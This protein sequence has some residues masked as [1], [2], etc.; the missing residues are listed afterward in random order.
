MFK[1]RAAAEPIFVCG[2]GRSGTTWI[3][4]ALGQSP[5]L[6]YIEEAWLI[7]KLEELTEWFTMV[8]DQ[9]DAF[10][11]WR[12][13]GVDRRAF[14]EGVARMY[15]DLLMRAANGKRFVEKTPEWNA[16][17]LKF[18]HELFPDAYYVLI[19]RDGRN[20]VASLEA[21]KVGEQQEFD[22][23]ASCR[24]WARMMEGFA[25]IRSTRP[26]RRFTVIR[27]EDLLQDFQARF[28][29]LCQFTAIRPFQ[30]KPHPPNSFF[31]AKHTPEDFTSR[32]HSWPAEKRLM[33]KQ[34]AGR[35]LVASGYVESDD[36]W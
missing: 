1:R 5:E 35:Q 19:Y 28:A 2:L 9:W 6:T 7:A 13:S 20:Y 8:H 29:E 36:A 30:P 24:R 4:R 32:W 22:F 23:A 21:K 26:I 33:F 16:A 25:D 14:V 11:P 10:T 18:L 3:S 27:Y 15:R 34:L 17:H 12:R 31:S